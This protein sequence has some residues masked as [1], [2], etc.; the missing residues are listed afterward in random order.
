M[1]KLTGALVLSFSLLLISGCRSAG[2]TRDA[3]DASTPS[4]GSSSGQTIPA[5]IKAAQETL[6]NGDAGSGSAGAGTGSGQGL[7]AEKPSAEGSTAATLSPA[8]RQAQEGCVDKWLTEKK[9]DRYG[10]AEGTMYAGGTPLFDERTGESRDRLDYVYERQP[11][12]K[13]TCVGATGQA[14]Q[15]GIPPKTK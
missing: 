2:E 8:E 6:N 12:A 5:A 1:K 13:K 3:E 7:T 14:P 9:L 15:K 10:N 4:S 11:E